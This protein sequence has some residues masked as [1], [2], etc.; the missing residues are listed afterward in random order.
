MHIKKLARKSVYIIIANLR[1]YCHRN[2]SSI[3]LKILNHRISILN[4]TDELFQWQKKRKLAGMIH[5]KNI[6]KLK[7]YK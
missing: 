7:K 5:S 4:F 1:F 6:Y 2:N 3:K